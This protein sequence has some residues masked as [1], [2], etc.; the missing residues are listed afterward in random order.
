MFS[1]S[2]I[3]PTRNRY[4]YLFSVIMAIVELIDRKDL[5]IIIQDNS[6]DNSDALK[7]F[8]N[9]TDSR[10]KYFYTKGVLPISD[11]VE[12]AIGNASKEYLT[13]IGDDDFV[14]PNICEIVD[15]IGERNIEVLTY[16]CGFY[17]WD[18]VEFI[19]PTAARQKKAFWIP[20]KSS[21]IHFFEKRCS[22]KEL[23]K[24]LELGAVTIGDM[25]K[26]YHGVINRKLLK[27]LKDKCGRYLISSCPDICLSSSIAL[28]VDYHYHLNY[29]VTICGAS[30]D[31]AAG[32]GARNVHYAELDGLLFLRP[33]ITTI[34]DHNIPRVWSPTTIYAQTVSEVLKCLQ[35]ELQ[36]NYIAMYFTMFKNER[37]LIK[38]IR[39]ALKG[40]LLRNPFH[41]FRSIPYIINK[42][43]NRRLV[44][45]EAQLYDVFIIDKVVDCMSKMDDYKLNLKEE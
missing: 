16:D 7:F 15:L 41:L 29:P 43:I 32:L 36:I 34:W 26:V 8:E 4:Q 33:E 18:S 12:K 27:K 6:D 5:E 24:V 37:N 38:Y 22:K 20:K 35:P 13:F 28:Q 25:P 3:I 10:V 11:N 31:S 44:I 2:I 39:P 30:R 21:G 45:P 17:W 19:A 14:A 1:L 40:Y 23:R 42:F 9:F